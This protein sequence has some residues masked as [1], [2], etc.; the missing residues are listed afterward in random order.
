MHQRID[1]RPQLDLS[2][3][4]SDRGTYLD[5][6]IFRW[7]YAISRTFHLDTVPAGMLTLIV[8]SISGA[9]QAEDRLEQRYQVGASAMA[10]VTTP[11][12]ASV[13]RAPPGMEA[14]DHVHL[15]VEEGGFLEYLPEHRI[16]FPDS[17]LCQRLGLG[18]GR[19]RSCRTPS[20]A[21]IRPGATP[22]SVI[23]PPRS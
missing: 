22:G 9:I 19:P 12:A 23:S 6:R 3:A 2:F 14:L 4:H 5:R 13:Y 16:L 1:V 21:M 20:R 17:W 10:H 11:G 8:Q 18:A 15:V 7:P